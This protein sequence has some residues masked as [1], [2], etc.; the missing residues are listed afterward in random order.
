M[1]GPNRNGEG[2]LQRL[3]RYCEEQAAEA[4]AD[5]DVVST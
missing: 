2:V 4:A 5:F 3:L 1:L